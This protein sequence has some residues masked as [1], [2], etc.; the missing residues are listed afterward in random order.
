MQ[1]WLQIIYFQGAWRTLLFHITECHLSGFTIPQFC[2][3]GSRPLWSNVGSLAREYLFLSEEQPWQITLGQSFDI[4]LGTCEDR[5]GNVKWVEQTRI[6]S[7]Y[8]KFKGSPVFTSLLLSLRASVEFYYLLAKNAAQSSP[9]TEKWRVCKETLSLPELPPWKSSL[10]LF[11]NSFCG[12]HEKNLSAL[13]FS[14]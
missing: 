10:L 6:S 9:M 13:W 3:W 5:V 1:G 12:H 7:F 14:N 11:K 8:T 4:G 2:P